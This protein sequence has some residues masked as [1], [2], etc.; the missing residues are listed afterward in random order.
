MG[1]ARVGKTSILKQYLEEKFDSHEN[2]SLSAKFKT[3][4]VKFK[5]LNRSIKFDLWDTVGQERYRSVAKI[6]YKNAKVGIPVYNIINRNSFEQ[7]NEYWYKETKISCSSPPIYAL[8]ANKTDLYMEQV[9]SHD[10]GKNFTDSIGAI[11]QP[12][13]ALSNTGNDKLFDNIG[14]K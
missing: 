5:D 4:T 6:F 10:E 7:L 1:E 11:F 14:R 12:T 2:T 8:V 13:S 9:V 3:K